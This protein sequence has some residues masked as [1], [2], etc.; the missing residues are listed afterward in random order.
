MSISDSCRLVIVLFDD[1]TGWA[2][3]CQR[4][5]NQ[6]PH[7]ARLGMTIELFLGKN[8]FPIDRHLKRP[9]CARNQVPLADE[10]LDLTLSQN[11]LRQTDGTRGVVS[12]RA[13]F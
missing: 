1:H 12:S 13:I 2:N 10:G 7:L 9:T 8:Q 5:H 11:F 3:F 6:L 4:F